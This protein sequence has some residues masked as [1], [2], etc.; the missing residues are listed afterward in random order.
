MT[1]PR[2]KAKY[3]DAAASQAYNQ[4]HSRGWVMVKIGT[5]DLATVESWFSEFTEGKIRGGEGR[6]RYPIH[7]RSVVIQGPCTTLS[8]GL[9]KWGLLGGRRVR[10][11]PDGKGVGGLQCTTKCKVHQHPHYDF[12]SKVVSAVVMADNDRVPLSCV[13]GPAGRFEM[14][15]DGVERIVPHGWA[16]VLRAD[17]EHGGGKR[18][19]GKKRFFAHVIDE[20]KLP[21]NIYDKW[22]NSI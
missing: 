15:L 12:S 6:L 3:R 8:E 18:V 20:G 14:L 10:P 5:E 1:R 22:G 7:D 19:D 16:V 2:T 4:L 11:W 9:A 13:W 17:C 21:T